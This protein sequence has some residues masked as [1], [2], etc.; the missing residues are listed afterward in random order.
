VRGIAS[1]VRM[2]GL[3]RIMNRIATNARINRWYFRTNIRDGKY[4]PMKPETRQRL[5]NYFR[6]DIIKLETLIGRDLSAWL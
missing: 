1:I 3:E 5:K 6:D 4:P 2:A